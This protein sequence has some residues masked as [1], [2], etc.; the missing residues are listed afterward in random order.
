MNRPS[1]ELPRILLIEDEPEV[2]RFLRTSLTAQGYQVIEATNGRDG[3][4]LAGQHRPVAVLLDLGLPDT[5]G[6]AVLVQLREWSSVPVIVVSARGQER[7]KVEALD[8]GA[9]DYLT[10]PFGLGELLAR[11]RAALR[12]RPADGDDALADGV[13]DAVRR[14]GRLTIDTTAHR[15]LVDEAPVHL[16]PIEFRILAVLA[17]HAGRVVTQKQLL[18][19]VWGPSGTDRGDSLR[20]FMTHLRRKLEADPTA[21]R[22]FHTEAGVGYR[23]ID[24]EG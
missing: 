11:L 22:L 7:Q 12:H 21:P 9:D 4:A 16:T 8:A 14:F 10:K 1:S 24:D 15:V 19:A 23:L 2:R 13:A 6:M 18:T 17:R 3:L 5:D 20:V